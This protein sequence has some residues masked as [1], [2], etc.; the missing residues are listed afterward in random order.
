MDQQNIMKIA[1]SPIIIY[2]V[3]AFKLPITFFTELV[4]KKKKN[5]FLW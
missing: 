5:M 2:R 3:N 4:G 1:L